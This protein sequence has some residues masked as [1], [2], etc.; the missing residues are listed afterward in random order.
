MRGLIW[1][2]LFAALFVLINWPWVYPEQHTELKG[3]V[4]FKSYP[5][6]ITIAGWPCKYYQ[7]SGIAGDTTVETFSWLALIANIAIWTFTGFAAGLYHRL[8][9]GFAR[10]K[11]N[12]EK[13]LDSAVDSEIRPKSAPQ[14]TIGNWRLSDLFVATAIIAAAFGY[15][16]LIRSRQMADSVLVDEITSTGGAAKLASRLPTS[17]YGQFN[18]FLRL[19]EVELRNPSDALVEKVVNLPYLTNLFILGGNYDL[20]KLA[21]LAQ[22]PLLIELAIIG[23]ELDP[24]AIQTIGQ[25][26]SLKHLNLMRTNVT[27]QGIVA[28]GH[29][30]LRGLNIV[31]TDVKLAELGRPQFADSL[32]TLHVPHPAKGEGDSLLV[33]SWPVLEE[34][35]CYEHDEMMNPEPVSLKLR[36]LPKLS[37]LKVDL[38]QLFDL[39][40]EQL[41]ELSKI[42]PQTYQWDQRTTVKQVVPSFSWIRNFRLRSA[43][44]LKELPIF[45]TDT[46]S[47]DIDQDE[48]M[49]FGLC[50]Y[51]LSHKRDSSKYGYSF[52]DF[53]GAV[54]RDGSESNLMPPGY[55]DSRKLD[56]KM[57]QKWIN[58]LGLCKGIGRL[59]LGSV[60]LDG[61][62]LSPISK[63]SFI[64]HLDLGHSNVS[65]S[66]LKALAGMDQLESLSLLGLHLDG[67]IIEWLAMNFPNLHKLE[68]EPYPVRRLR[69]E[70]IPNL[71]SVFEKPKS[72]NQNENQNY[73][74]NYNQI[75]NQSTTQSSL[76]SSFVYTRPHQLEALK[77]VEAPKL[78]DVF[79]SQVPM[80]LLHVESAPS[81][82]GLSF[83]FPLPAN[84]ELRGLR[85]LQY[86]GA[87]GATCNDALVSEVLNCTGLK[88]L[89]LAYSSVT[90]ETLTKIAGLKELEYLVLTGSAVTDQV[91]AA[92]AE[93][94][95]LKTL[96][97]DQTQITDHAASLVLRLKNLQILELGELKLPTSVVSELLKL[98]HLKSLNL[99]GCDVTAEHLAELNNFNFLLLL[100][101]SRMALT[102]EQLKVL[103]ENLPSSLIE[104]RLNETKL[105]ARGFSDLVRALPESVHFG[106][107]GTDIDPKLMDWL[108]SQNRVTELNDEDERNFNNVL[109]GQQV[110]IRRSGIVSVRN[111]MSDPEEFAGDIDPSVFAPRDPKFENS[112][113]LG[114]NFENG[115]TEPNFN[116]GL[117]TNSNAW[118]LPM[119]PFQRL[120]YVLYRLNNWAAPK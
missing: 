79:N 29:I 48:P 81:L 10:R 40:L 58:D 88:R 104:L 6:S 22:N 37:I 73:D 35:A 75:Y 24:Q 107:S 115:A 2:A 93:L 105:D 106:L 113:D 92:L 67:S 70:R 86:F 69:L 9:R 76:Q 116:P 3:R 1:I 53:P 84:A 45:A 14:N 51:D 96:R 12:V 5:T 44:K 101:L 4:T 83:Q 47:I 63:N 26:K 57:R 78:R 25:L 95:Q 16:Q 114:A 41:P 87:G 61:L 68:C 49:S 103:A 42:E 72:N 120:G 119:N 32:T 98:T 52:V 90:P 60:P 31:H 118:P 71:V 43:P 38:L 56:R 117:G 46:D 28:L 59:D 7:S 109:N 27:A 19:T 94:S 74:Q 111:A 66:Q 77:I 102:N 15:W 8:S 20:K 100:D 85:D 18:T 13:E 33:E 65:A 91:V 34:L 110:R 89:T 108:V 23:R 17:F 55:L 30:K 112:I 39:D 99:S 50:V 62:D 36:N 21:P 54:S 80:L 97:L 11:P 82:R 64:K